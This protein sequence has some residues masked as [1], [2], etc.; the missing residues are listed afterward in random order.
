MRPFLLIPN[1]IYPL[2]LSLSLSSW[3]KT[4][5]RKKRKEERQL[6]SWTIHLCYIWHVEGVCQCVVKDWYI[7]MFP[8]AWSCYL[9]RLLRICYVIFLFQLPFALWYARLKL[10]YKFLQILIRGTGVADYYNIILLRLNLEVHI[11]HCSR[12][13]RL[14]ALVG[15]CIV[16]NLEPLAGG[17][18]SSHK[19]I[20]HIICQFLC[21]RGKKSKR[22]LILQGIKCQLAPSSHVRK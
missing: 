14:A 19:L 21:A 15:V 4:E 1:F 22:G 5:K 11:F 10:S 2:S 7:F 13:G 9:Q 20:P 12:G 6:C 16:W 18:Q 8:R 17:G 3:R